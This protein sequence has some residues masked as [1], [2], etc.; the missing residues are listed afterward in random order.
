MSD[1]TP[2]E[3]MQQLRDRNSPFRALMRTYAGRKV[4]LFRLPGNQGDEL[5]VRGALQA[6]ESSQRALER[7][8]CKRHGKAQSRFG[9]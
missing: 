7:G 8:P 1:S 5:I 6:L 4:Y 9:I 3:V 2:L